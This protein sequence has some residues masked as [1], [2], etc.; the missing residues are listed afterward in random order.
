MRGHGLPGV[1]VNGI[2]LR[3]NETGCESPELMVFGVW[4]KRLTAKACSARAALILRARG[5]ASP[6]G[7]FSVNRP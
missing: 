3:R 4:Q 2:C 7:H 1:G 6:S 5:R